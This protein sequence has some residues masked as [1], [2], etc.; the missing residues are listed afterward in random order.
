ME[1][2]WRFIDD[3]NWEYQVS[4]LGRVRKLDSVRTYETGACMLREGK[5]LDLRFNRNGYVIVSLHING[6]CCTRLVHRLVALAFIPK[7][8]GKPD[9][10]HKNGDKLDN[11]IDNLEWCTKLENIE[12]AQ[13]TG[14]CDGKRTKEYRSIYCIETDTLYKGVGA[15]VKHMNTK[16]TSVLSSINQRRPIIIGDKKYTFLRG[17][18]AEVYKSLKSKFDALL[19]WQFSAI[20]TDLGFYFC[21]NK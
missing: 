2:V 15:V 14:L 6:K 19:S 1:E 11:S 8:Y 18:D 10:N 17:I 5:M 16:S 9:V 21:L 3:C 4:N 20:D 13:R 7:I 12:H